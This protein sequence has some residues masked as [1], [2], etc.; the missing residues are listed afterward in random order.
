MLKGTQLIL[1][2]AWLQIA[3]D[4]VL[5]HIHMVAGLGSMKAVLESPIQVL[6]QQ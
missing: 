5:G 6:L 1:M 2:A 3:K 4:F